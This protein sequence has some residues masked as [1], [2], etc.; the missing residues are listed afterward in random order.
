[1]RLNGLSRTTL[2]ELTER[3]LRPGERARPDV[4]VVAVDG[5]RWVVKDYAT[6][7]PRF[8]RLLGAYLVWRERVA[9]ERAQDLAGVPGLVGT[10]GPYALVTEFVEATEVTSA[11]AE[12][13]DGDFFEQLA[14]LVAGLHALGVVH[15]DL[16]KL[17]NILVTPDG[18]P[19]VVD[20]TAAFVNGSDPVAALVFPWICDDDVRAIYKLKLRC[21]PHLLTAEEEAFLNQRGLAERFFRW[22]RR[23]IRYA[24]KMLST[25]EH[26]RAEIRL[27]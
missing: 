21:A 25:P 1:M 19:V 18:R 2:P 16:K 5:D 15:G 12:L 6:G 3:V 17:E 9:Y 26:Q 13:L 10:L 4:R 14:E 8:K 27:K 7:G 20:F 24:A 22:F 11:P 23:Y